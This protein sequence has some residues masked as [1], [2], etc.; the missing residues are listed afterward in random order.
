MFTPTLS[1]E[2]IAAFDSQK[3]VILSHDGTPY[4]GYIRQVTADEKIEGISK[5][6]VK[7]FGA[8]EENNAKA[9]D[10]REMT[11]RSSPFAMF[12]NI[13]YATTTAQSA[14]VLATPV[15][16]TASWVVSTATSTATLTASTASTQASAPAKVRKRALGPK[17]YA[18]SKTQMAAYVHT[19]NDYQKQVILKFDEEREFHGWIRSVNE[20]EGESSRY[21]VQMYAIGP[22]PKATDD[23]QNV[24]IP[25]TGETTPKFLWAFGKVQELFQT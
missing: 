6:T 20:L 24:K 14:T 9:T 16:Q 2:Q 22:Q 25:I 19:G 10:Y 5:F 11:L 13:T 21:I 15:V 8:L 23:P 17:V 18:P 4:R 1:R 7:F 12:E 3:L